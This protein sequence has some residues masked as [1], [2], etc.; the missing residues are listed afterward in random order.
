MCTKSLQ[1]C[2]TLCDPIDYSPPGSSVH[3]IL[4]ARNLQAKSCHALLQ[5]IFPTQG[6][7]LSLAS[8]HWF[9][10]ELCHLGNPS[11]IYVIKLLFDFI[12]LICLISIC[13]LD[14]PE[15]P[16][17]AEENL[18]LPDNWLYWNIRGYIDKDNSI[19]EIFLGNSLEVQC[20]GLRRTSTARGLGLI[21]GKG[22]KI[23]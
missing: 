3:G 19:Q 7:N 16:R 6:Q 20:L 23:P 9:F 5:G 1:L 15:E 18:F 14:Q 8:L 10:Y 2:S 21:S 13:F 4:Q 22:T 12:P 11:Q 17:K